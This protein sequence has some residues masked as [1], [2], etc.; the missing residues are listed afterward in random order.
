MNAST[1]ARRIPPWG[2]RHDAVREEG[3]ELPDRCR[4]GGDRPGADP[5]LAAPAGYGRMRRPTGLR[6]RDPDLAAGTIAFHRRYGSTM[7][8]TSSRE[9]RI[10]SGFVA[11]NRGRLAQLVRAHA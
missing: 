3:G 11:R 4:V 1:C 2:G 8:G 5:S 9:L 7:G 6:R 10:P